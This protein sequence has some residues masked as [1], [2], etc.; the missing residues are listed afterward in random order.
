MALQQE[1]YFHV[2]F[3]RTNKKIQRNKITEKKLKKNGKQT[4]KYE[5]N[6][7][8]NN[9]NKTHWEKCWVGGRGRSLEKGFLH[10]NSGSL[11]SR[12][13]FVNT[14]HFTAFLAS[15][16]LLSPSPTP[17]H[18]PQTS[19]P[20]LGNE[21]TL[22]LKIRKKPFVF[23]LSSASW[24]SQVLNIKEQETVKLCKYKLRPIFVIAYHI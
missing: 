18:F 2:T 10:L 11:M 19:S 20:L 13:L 21:W 5:M 3:E 9:N 4:Y 22:S 16:T 1:K 6:P 7:S 14:L 17:V 12:E 8:I 23:P 15:I 24:A